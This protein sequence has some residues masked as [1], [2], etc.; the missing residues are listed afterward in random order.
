MS[1]APTFGGFGDFVALVQLVR[2]TYNLVEACYHAT[3][4]RKVVLD[5][6]TRF[7]ESLNALTPIFMTLVSMS[8]EDVRALGPSR[9]ETLSYIGQA[10]LRDIEGC[11]GAIE[12]FSHKV[13]LGVVTSPSSTRRTRALNVL[14]DIKQRLRWTL[15]LSAQAT[16]LQSELND[17]THHMLLL[18]TGSSL[19]LYVV[20]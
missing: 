17:R 11:R 5:S 14:R 18:A 2:S 1:F 16:A 4:A 8:P 7:E 20:S 6:F 9:T 10:I 19:N 13:A 3:K 12:S 15:S